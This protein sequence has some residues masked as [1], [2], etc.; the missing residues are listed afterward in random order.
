MRATVWKQHLQTLHSFATYW[1]NCGQMHDLQL[2]CNLCAVLCHPCTR[3][4]HMQAR[5]AA[6]C[7]AVL[8]INAGMS[9]CLVTTDAAVTPSVCSMEGAA[10]IEGSHLLRAPV[11]LTLKT[12][13]LRGF[14]ST[15]HASNGLQ[16]GTLAHDEL[17]HFLLGSCCAGG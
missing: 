6:H 12:A 17:H 4:K 7:T 1:S 11:V 5:M 10:T 2:C 14:V 13:P 9:N 8:N 3:T 16:Q 15:A